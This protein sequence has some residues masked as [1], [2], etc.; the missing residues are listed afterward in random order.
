METPA[1]AIDACD[2]PAIEIPTCDNV[3]D[4]KRDRFTGRY[5]VGTRQLVGI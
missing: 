4:A 1:I 3:L 5:N 2:A